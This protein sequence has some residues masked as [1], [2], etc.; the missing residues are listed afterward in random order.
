META[1]TALAVATRAAVDRCGR[2]HVS[3]PLSPTGTEDGQDWGGGEQETNDAPRRQKAPSPGSR[4][5]ILAEPGPH[6]SDRNQ[7]PS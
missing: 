4:P 5:G 3:A 6:R 1:T 2:G 7:R